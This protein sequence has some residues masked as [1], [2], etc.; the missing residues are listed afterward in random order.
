MAIT[1]VEAHKRETVTSVSAVRRGAR[2]PEFAT[3]K[4]T[5]AHGCGREGGERAGAH[6]CGQRVGHRSQ[7]VRAGG[8]GVKRAS[9]GVH[10]CRIGG[11][12]W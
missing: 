7:A 2:R 10:R 12:T 4:V 3:V 9:R 11:V 6:G 5:L 8:D 1:S